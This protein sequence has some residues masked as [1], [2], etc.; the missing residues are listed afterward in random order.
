MT[1]L[2]AFAWRKSTASSSTSNDHRH[3]RRSAFP[4]SRPGNNDNMLT[5]AASP[6][7]SEKIFDED[8]GVTSSSSGETL[9]YQPSSDSQTDVGTHFTQ[10]KAH[11]S[12]EVVGTPDALK[13]RKTPEE[14]REELG[15][16]PKRLLWGDAFAA[17][18]Q[19]ITSMAA[20]LPPMMPHATKNRVLSPQISTS[21][22]YSMAGDSSIDDNIARSPSL[23]PGEARTAV[24]ALLAM[25]EDIAFDDRHRASSNASQS[26]TTRLL[27]ENSILPSREWLRD[28]RSVEDNANDFS[29]ELPYE[30]LN[31]S[32]CSVAESSIH[33]IAE[34]HPN[35]PN[36]SFTRG[37]LEYETKQS[38]DFG[39]LVNQRNKDGDDESSPADFSS[40]M[41][42]S[43]TTTSTNIE[44]ESMQSMGQG[45]EQER[46]EGQ[47]SSPLLDY[48]LRETEDLIVS[49]FERLR[50]DIGLVSTVLL[51]GMGANRMMLQ[52]SS[53]SNGE[54][55]TLMEFSSSARQAILKSFDGLQKSNHSKAGFQQILAFYRSLVLASSPPADTQAIVPR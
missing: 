30:S 49:V 23:R 38:Y 7:N 3:Q 39:P 25:S 32:L 19:K 15:L 48:G 10:T 52:C 28:D 41:S 14:I 13:T 45:M 31:E 55:G 50:D 33:S 5:A 40:Y 54:R 16:A 53:S 36:T 1:S 29:I 34:H 47:G 20:I 22:F 17:E 27:P 4:L 43:S 37:F 9:M 24:G 12:L 26:K 35:L 18:T 51:R 42:Q 44:I 46:V 21:S 11:T 6:I 2:L 8:I